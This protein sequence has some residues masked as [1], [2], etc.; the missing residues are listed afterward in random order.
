MTTLLMIGTRKGL[1]LAR[2]EDRARWGVEGPASAMH[3]V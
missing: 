2:S 1:F 3:A